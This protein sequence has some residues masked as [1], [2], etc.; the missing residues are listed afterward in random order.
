MSSVVAENVR[1]HDR[2][3][4]YYDQ[5]HT[6]IFNPTE[7]R[8]LARAV[9]EALGHVTVDHRRALD[10]GCGTGNLTAKLLANGAVVWAADLSGEMLRVLHERRRS[11]L[12]AGRLKPVQLSGDLPLPFPTG[13]FAFVGSYSV[14]HHVP[15]YLAAVRELARVVAPG[16]VLFIDHEA[17]EDHWRSPVGIR[18]HRMLSFPRYSLGRIGARVALLRRE[19][20]L[21][22]PAPL[23]REVTGE[24]DVHVHADDHIEWSAIRTM[25]SHI[26]LQEILVRDYLLCRE[27]SRFPMRYWLCRGVAAD[28]KLVVARKRPTDAAA[29]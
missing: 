28:T 17:N 2:V 29:R 9:A 25:L 12:Q 22:L 15:D 16:G 7:Q 20:E 3:A 23:Q 19:P 18:V 26:G 27:T 24:G 4:R 8:R 5:G 6:E 11:E 21:P 1:R 10:F 13:Y 14:L